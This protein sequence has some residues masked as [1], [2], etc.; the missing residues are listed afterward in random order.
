MESLLRFIIKIEGWIY[1]VFGIVLFISV[2]NTAIHARK[3]RLAVF[4]LEQEIEKK[5]LRAYIS[6][7]IFSLLSI[8][9]VLFITSY[10]IVKYP[11]IDA[12]LTPTISFVSTPTE[13][14]SFGLSLSDNSLR[15]EDFEKSC[16]SGKLEWLS[17]LDGQIVQ[18]SINLI[19]TVQ[20]DNFAFYRYS[21]RRIDE[22]EWTIIAIGSQQVNEGSLGSDWDTTGIEPGEYQLGLFVYDVSNVLL[23]ACIIN[24]TIPF[25]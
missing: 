17:P 5:D 19:G 6:L 12:I 25:Q 22:I 24:I 4:G 20:V 11:G 3:L 21:F 7:G 13:G 9:G 18:G 1:F 23:P 2:I 16:E 10:S 8:M 15:M 14:A